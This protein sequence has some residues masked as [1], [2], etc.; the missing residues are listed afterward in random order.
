LIVVVLGTL[1][2]AVFKLENFGIAVVGEVP[3]G[4]PA[5]RLPVF[6]WEHFHTLLPMA[7]TL[8]VISYTETISIGQ[9]LDEKNGEDRVDANQELLSLGTSNLIGSLF[10]SYTGT[11]SFSRSAINHKLKAHTPLAG[12]IGVVLVALTLLF[13]TPFFHDLPEAALASIIMVSVAGLIEI[14]YPALLWKHQK[15][16]FFVLVFTFLATLFLG[17]LHGILFGVLLSLIMVLYRT[18]K[19]HFAVLGKIKNTE[20]YKN[21]ERFRNDVEVRDDLL[22][23]RFDSQLYFGN[24]NYFKKQLH[25][26]MKE[27]GNALRCIILN[28]EGIT[29]IDSTATAMLVKF[30]DE[31]QEKKMVFYITG[32]IGPT[33]DVIFNSPIIE[34]LPKKH[35]FLG[36]RE[37]V[38]YFDKRQSVTELQERIAHQNRP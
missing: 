33:R 22:I 19:P 28:A 9:S 25:K 24:K 20:Y 34:F 15:D 30:I 14:R 36:V 32:A 27:K 11:A 2:V 16:E 37:A 17:I 18:S 8:A 38:D 13:L 35:L 1:G 29:Y 26:F 6:N 5:F 23:V 3:R 31:I 10:Q 7:V 21:I 12:V 4:L